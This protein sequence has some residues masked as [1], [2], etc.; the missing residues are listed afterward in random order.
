MSRRRSPRPISAAL[1]ETMSRAAPATP[2]AAIQAAWTN[3]VGERIAA[4]ARP[5]AERDGVLTVSC[6]SASW[7]QELDL[8]AG[9]LLERL[10]ETVPE[11]SAPQSLRFRAIEP[12][13]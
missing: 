11:G 5:V 13:D 12:L 4:Q 8:L 1:A 9:D 7:A 2:L 3:A 6:S 10:R